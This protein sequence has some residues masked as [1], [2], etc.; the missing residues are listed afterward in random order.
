MNPSKGILAVDIETAS[1]ADLK[2]VGQWAYAADESTD[3]YCV[4]F[5][6][7]ERDGRYNYVTWEPG[8]ELPGGVVDFITAGGK[9]VAHNASFEISIWRNIL[10]PRYGFPALELEQVDDTQIRGLAVNLPMSLGGL[11]KAL[12]CPVQKDTEGKALMLKMCKLTAAGVGRWSNAHDTRPNRA[13]LV[14]YCRDDVGATLDCFYRLKP[15]G[16]A[17]ELAYRV[18]KRIN[19]RGVYL[20]RKFAEDCMAVVLAR[21]AEL[22]TEVLTGATDWRAIHVKDSRNPS[23]LKVFLKAH[24]VAIPTRTRKKTVDGKVVHRKSEST[25]KA[26][27]VEMLAQED[28]H[29]DV[30]MVLQNRLESTKAT[31]LSKLARVAD[32]VGR[33]GRLR[34]ALQ[35]YGAGTGRWTSSGLQVHNLPKDKLGDLADAVRECI[36]GR[37]LEGLKFLVD[38]PLEAVSSCLRSILCAAPGKE[39]IAADWSA[40]EARVVAWLAG[41]AD[42]LD[43]FA[44]GEDIYVKA[45]R[46]IGSDSRPLGKVAT[47][48]LGYGMGVLTFVATAA[49]W[50]I[51]LDL[52]EARR[53][54]KAWREAN[55]AIVGFWR[56]IEEAAKLAIDEPGTTFRAGR[57]SAIAS[58][59]CLGLILPSGRTLRYWRPR[60]VMTETTIK[61][62]DDEGN[63]EEKDI[64]REEIRFFTMGKDKSS[65]VEE[66]TY[67]GKLAENV[68]QAVARD[69]L[70]AATVRLDRED[71]YRLVMHVHDSLVAEVDAGEGSVQHF[72]QALAVAPTWAGGLPLAAEG[73]RSTYFRG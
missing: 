65:M 59:G 49:K 16:I 23:A 5:G 13:R 45:A 20:D 15:L 19:A 21:K 24:G 46:D 40:I 61:I 33:D 73:Y 71:P 34:F 2:R 18:D 62:V 55:A 27:V 56:D 28:V 66:S 47:L 63:I 10:E 7:A 48:A 11:A 17:E 72:E 38:R 14:A 69:L 54:Q 60:L 8:D 22:D 25:D 58:R 64:V 43:V 52:K 3:V 26:A 53:I 44:R 1:A 41:Q 30:R 57:I 42:V 31:S 50:G 37:D 67:G 6:Y 29:P 39:L 35:L 70:A 9:V 51:A 4:V 36:R 12:G 68:T 32:M